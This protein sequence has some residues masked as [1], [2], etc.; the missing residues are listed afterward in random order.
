MA[1]PTLLFSSSATPETSTLRLR[2]GTNATEAPQ[3]DY[4]EHVFFPF[5]RRHFDI[6]IRL[7]ILTRGYYPKGGGEARLE[8]RSRNEPL[9]AVNVVE[10]GD[11]ISI[12][13]RAFV[14]GIPIRYAKT[15]RD[16]AVASLVKKGID[17]SIIE[18]EY[19]REPPNK[20]V[21]AGSGIVLWAE[22]DSGC[23][24]GGSSIGKKGVKPD[25]LGREAAEELARNLKHG[26][27]VDEYLQDQWVI[28]GALAKGKSRLR[29]GLPITLHTRYVRAFYRHF[30]LTFL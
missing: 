6:D 23:T 15:C 5:L 29:C 30:M 28:F 10:R 2:G 3:L 1:L 19:L 21:G 20:A 12:R 17:P 4:A 11:V 7:D 16:A 14:A 8:V 26:G 27:C 9:P 18:V 13:G 25:D 22:T 24:I